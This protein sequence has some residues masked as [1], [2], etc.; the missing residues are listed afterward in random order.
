MQKQFTKLSLLLFLAI[1]SANVIAQG[2]TTPR[3]P[4][5]AAK[6]SQTVGISTVT[7]KYSRPS[8]KNREVWG[9]LVPYGW[10]VQAFG[11]GNEAP[12]RAGANEN[13]VIEFSH[14]AKVEGQT[15]P[16][17]TYGLFF[18]INKDNSGEVILSKDS[19]SWGS[20]WYNASQDQLRAKIKVRDNSHVELLT[21]DF[22]NLTKTTAELVLNWEKKQFPVAIEFN[23]DDLV[24]ANAAEELKGPIGFNWQGYSSAANYAL[25]NKVNQEKGLVW[26]DQAI[27]Q[28]KSFAT[29]N[30]KSGL[31]KLAGNTAE[32]E[33]IASEAIAG[34]TE[35][36]LNVYGYQ[37]LNN[38]QHDKAVEILALNTQRFPKSANAWD[39]LG[40]AYATKGDKPNA[41]KNF[42]KSLSLNPTAAVKANSEKFLKQLGAI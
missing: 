42:K 34:A 41:I 39:S 5:P 33:K 14:P 9:N 4:S 16:A 32:S 26:I 31:L 12:W 35:A 15:V 1:V 20:F 30:I 17:G 11:A 40:E 21:Y 2:I 27:A 38:G 19:R 3:T 6:T 37:L 24:M 7:V 36:E 13:T 22:I 23:V 8:V 18:V 10:N 25:Q 28:N 29:L